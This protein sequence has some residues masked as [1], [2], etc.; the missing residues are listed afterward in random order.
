[1]TD[2][3]VF[4]DKER[5]AK[6]VAEQVEQ[7]AS[8]GSMYAMGAERDG[9]LVAG[10]VMNNYNGVNATVHLAVKKP[11]KD[12]VALFRAFCDYAFNVCKLKRITGLVPA[13][14]PKVLA[15]DLKL[16]FEEEF[17]MQ[18]AAQDGGP[19]HIL[20]MTPDTCRWLKK[21]I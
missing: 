9:E 16:G 11:G 1:M 20:K 3:L 4:D 10:V 5:V 7:S 19:L 13:S 6:W 15:F 17:V 2:R 12:M 14:L 8:W 21:G 18:E